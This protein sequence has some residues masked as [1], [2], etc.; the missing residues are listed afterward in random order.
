MATVADTVGALVAAFAPRA[1]KTA[2]LEVAAAQLEIDP[3][4]V[5][6]ALSRLRNQGKIEAERRGVY[7]LSQAVQFRQT[8]LGTWRERLDRLAPWDG[9][10]FV[11]LTSWLPKSNRKAARARTRALKRLGFREHHPGV[12]LRPANLSLELDD[13]AD[14]M[15]RLG[16][17]EAGDILTASQVTFD[18][19]GHWHE[20]ID[21]RGRAETLARG[22]RELHEDDSVHGAVTAFRTANHFIREAVRD[23]LLPDAWVDAEARKA[24]WEALIAYDAYGRSLW[25]TN[26]WDRVPVEVESGSAGAE[27][28]TAPSA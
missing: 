16:F 5:R 15:V 2:D 12:A 20:S 18:P 10:Y 14:L 9:S 8:A 1:V 13:M 17:D 19:R 24:F 7:R 6:V 25:K 4:Q 27:V 11:A 22:L 3:G 23:P 26:V 28:K 21:Y